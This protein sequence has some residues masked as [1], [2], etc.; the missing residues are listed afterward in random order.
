MFCTPTGRD[1]RTPTGRDDFEFPQVGNVLYSHKQG[2][3]PTA[4]D[5]FVNNSDSGYDDSWVQ[6]VGW[7]ATGEKGLWYMTVERDWLVERALARVCRKGLD[8]IGA[9]RK[10]FGL[11]PVERALDWP[12]ER[13]LDR[14]GGEACLMHARPTIFREYSNTE[15]ANIDFWSIGLILERGG[16]FQLLNQLIDL[17]L[18]SGFLVLLIGQQQ[19]RGDV[20][21]PLA[22][23]IC[24]NDDGEAS[25]R[26]AVLVFLWKPSVHIPF[27]PSVYA[28]DD[29]EA[30]RVFLS[31]PSVDVP[32]APSICV[33]NDGEASLQ[34]AVRVFLSTPSVHISSAPSVYVNDD[35]KASLWGAVM[36]YIKDGLRIMRLLGGATGSRVWLPSVGYGFG[37]NWFGS[38]DHGLD[39]RGVQGLRCH[40]RFVGE[41]DQ[42]ADP[43]H[44][45]LHRFSEGFLQTGLDSLR[46]NLPKQELV[47]QISGR[48]PFVLIGTKSLCPRRKGV[49]PACLSNLNGMKSKY[50]GGYERFDM[51]KD[52]S[53]KWRHAIF[54]NIQL[55]I[56]AIFWSN[57]SRHVFSDIS[58]HL[59][60]SHN[61]LSGPIPLG[62]QFPTFDESIYEG[63]PRLCGSP[64]L[65]KCE[66]ATDEEDGDHRGHNGDDR[67]DKYE[68]LGLFVSLSFGFIVG[69]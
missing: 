35:G 33:N 1:G 14:C 23:S 52:N 68:K 28:S 21:V 31:I 11:V 12:V 5:D 67:E 9:C 55:I 2:R 26:G 45:K 61:N 15:K 42:A 27:A 37:L 6:A 19:G 41:R 24:A 25:L 40:P 54:G 13:A 60:L 65:T 46:P 44:E 36:I 29:G 43:L 10:G 58:N 32:S 63:N 4:R 18:P 64:L 69:F 22:P 53:E 50:H 59:N 47:D 38:A 17:I 57:S 48:F 56:Q 66:A 39:D 3:T 34:G 16:G 49:I 30:V 7:R 62:N 8:W 20:D 51:E